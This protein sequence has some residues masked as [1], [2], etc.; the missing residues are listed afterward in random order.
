MKRTTLSI[1]ILTLVSGAA[2]ATG[3]HN[4]PTTPPSSVATT[5]T[6]LDLSIC[7]KIT[8]NASTNGPGT[9]TSNAGQN[10][11]AIGTVSAGTSSIPG[12]VAGS[13]GGKLDVYSNG[14]AS[15]VSTLAGTG[16]A[17]AQGVADGAA[18]ST[19]KYPANVGS[20]TMTG[21]TAAHADSK[22]LAGINEAGNASSETVQ[23][24]AGE[25][26]L[27]ADLV[28]GKMTVTGSV[29]DSKAGLS[30]VEVDSTKI[31]GHPVTTANAN[32]ST[33]V[34]G[35]VHAATGT[36]IPTVRCFTTHDI[37]G[38]PHQDCH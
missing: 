2:F 13:I 6:A 11:G 22:V 29:V 16:S 9:S 26:K 37:H 35:D 3:S 15:N 30:A 21:N 25:G 34:G 4:P 38:N 12:G 31:V 32:G 20:V 33:A 14:S 27:T 19:F 17:T 5:G 10:A 18:G 8:T 7:N 23:V 36:A 1:A 28:D 24:Y